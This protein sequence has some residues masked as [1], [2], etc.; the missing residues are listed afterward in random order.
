MDDSSAGRQESGDSGCGRALAVADRIAVALARQAREDLKTLQDR[1]GLSRTDIVNRAVSLFEFIDQ[2]IK[3]T[4]TTCSS[5]PRRAATS[6]WCACCDRA[7]WHH[8][9]RADVP[10]REATP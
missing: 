3:G 5:A 10:G 4:A 1:T 9:Q 6:S 2:Q 7:A 8:E